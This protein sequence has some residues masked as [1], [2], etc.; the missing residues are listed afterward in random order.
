MRL[1][2]YYKPN[3][4]K[5][6]LNYKQDKQYELPLGSINCYGHIIIQYWYIEDK[7]VFYSKSKYD[8]YMDKRYKR[9]PNLRY[10]LGQHII[11][12]GKWVSFGKKEKVKV[13]YVYRYPWWK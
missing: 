1:L 13:V 12:F 9:K 3:E 11:K 2:I 6:I 8:R 4:D 5:F 10:K 7:K